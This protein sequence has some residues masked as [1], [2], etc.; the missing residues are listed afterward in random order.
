MCVEYSTDQHSLIAYNRTFIFPLVKKHW[1]KCFD[2]QSLLGAWFIIIYF[3]CSMLF[4]DRVGNLKFEEACYYRRTYLQ[5]P[6]MIS[7]SL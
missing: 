2:L 7:S 5:F 3:N 4:C 1:W 6:P